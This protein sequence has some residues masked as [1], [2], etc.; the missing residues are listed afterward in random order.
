M[1]AATPPV[2]PAPKGKKKLPKPIIP[3][4]V[5]TYPKSL[6]NKDTETWVVPAG[7]FVFTQWLLAV[8]NRKNSSVR[9]ELYWDASGHFDN[10]TLVDVIYTDRASLQRQFKADDARYQFISNGKSRIVLKKYVMGK[11][12]N[13]EC[14]V[15]VQGTMF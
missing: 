13:R 2:A 9:V 15:K 11:T 14:F 7:N 5:L 8:E 1:T 12:G 10:P 3:N 4:V 6:S